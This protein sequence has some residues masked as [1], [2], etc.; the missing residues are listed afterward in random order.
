MY[1]YKY[2]LLLTNSPMYCVTFDEQRK[3]DFKRQNIDVY[4]LNFYQAIKIGRC[5]SQIS[6]GDD[7]AVSMLGRV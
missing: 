4:F 5:D 3:F 2:Y 1:N 6:N 7:P